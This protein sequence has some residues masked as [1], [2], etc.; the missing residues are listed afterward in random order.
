MA[1][2]IVDIHG[3]LVNPPQFYYQALNNAREMID[4]MDKEGVD[5]SDMV[6]AANSLIQ[7]INCY[8]A[9]LPKREGR[10]LD[11]DKAH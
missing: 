1:K 9:F 8:I 3:F 6:V 10:N 5:R 4:K 7:D 11:L 2:R